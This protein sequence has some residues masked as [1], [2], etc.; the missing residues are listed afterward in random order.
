MEKEQIIIDLLKT[1]DWLVKQISGNYA[2]MK[3]MQ[4]FYQPQIDKI[5]EI[6]EKLT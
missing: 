1:R 2:N 4:E 6:I 3:T 5:D